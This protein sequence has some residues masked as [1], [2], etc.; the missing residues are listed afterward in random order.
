MANESGKRRGGDA[1]RRE[2][3]G[4][5]RGLPHTLHSTPCTL[6]P[7]PYTLHP[8]PYT[9]LLTPCTVHPTPYTLRPTPFTLHPTPYTLH[10]KPDTLHPTPYTLH[11]TPFTLHPTPYTLHPT[12]EVLWK[13]WEP[14]HC[15]QPVILHSRARITIPTG[16][17]LGA[18]FP[19][20]GPSKT[21]PSHTRSCQSL[22]TL[23]DFKSCQT[24]GYDPFSKSQLAPINHLKGLLWCRSGHVTPPSTFRGNDTLELHRVKGSTSQASLVKGCFTCKVIYL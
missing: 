13:P 2:A 3:A 1:L 5:R 7:S 15:F 17:T 11:P 24:V 14:W 20:A 10:P 16:H 19:E 12:P 8:A 4:D 18:L 9:L 6:H 21:R 23:F 22:R